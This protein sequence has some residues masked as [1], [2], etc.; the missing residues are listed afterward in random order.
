[1]HPTGEERSH[2]LLIPEQGKRDRILREVIALKVYFN[3]A[4]DAAKLLV[5]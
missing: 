2:P 1:M 4:G 3:L 5:Q